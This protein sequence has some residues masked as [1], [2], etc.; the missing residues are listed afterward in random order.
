MMYWQKDTC[1]HTH[2]R[3]DLEQLKYAGKARETTEQAKT[4]PK[5]Q[6]GN[7]LIKQPILNVSAS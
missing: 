3:T 7:K 5:E 2:K 4:K 6:R 1:I